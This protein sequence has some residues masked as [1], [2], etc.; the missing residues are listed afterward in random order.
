MT[1]DAHVQQ[2]LDR[3]QSVVRRIPEDRDAEDRERDGDCQWF[4]DSTPEEIDACVDFQEAHE[5][6]AQLT[7]LLYRDYECD[8]TFAYSIRTPLRTRHFS[9]CLPEAMAVVLAAGSPESEEEHAD[10]ETVDARYLE[11][12]PV[13]AA[14]WEAVQNLNSKENCY[15]VMAWQVAGEEIARLSHSDNYDR[16]L[17][18][19]DLMESLK[20][21]N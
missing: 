16:D 11:N 20:E 12:Q 2:A 9:P 13:T 8:V 14:I 18:W 1:V 17:A 6:F 7:R 15:F 3:L 4:E 19:Y 10:L 5:A 21:E